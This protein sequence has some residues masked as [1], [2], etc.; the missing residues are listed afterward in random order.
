MR[1]RQLVVSTLA[2]LTGGCLRLTQS[3]GSGQGETSSG[4]DSG[5]GSGDGFEMRYA[6]ESGTLRS[7]IDGS[8]VAQAS[9][10]RQQ[11]NGDGY[12]V[13][14]VLTDEAARRLVET[15]QEIG[16]FEAPEE[17]PLFVYF[18]GREVHSFQLN[19]QLIADMRSGGFQENPT[20]QIIVEQQ[21][22][23]QDLS[24]SLQN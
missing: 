1:R 21:S 2:L 5:S 12:A 18:D 19:E 4:G 10:P 16:A 23:A 8:G 15:L 22:L 6:D 9:D 11:R 3:G 24:N 20:I 13:A 7:I 14:I 17:H